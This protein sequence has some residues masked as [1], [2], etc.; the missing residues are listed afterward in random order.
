VGSGTLE[1]RVRMATMAAENLI[2]GLNGEVPPNLVNSEALTR[3][4][5][6]K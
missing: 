4:G 3:R 1:T 2:A 5:L 6:I